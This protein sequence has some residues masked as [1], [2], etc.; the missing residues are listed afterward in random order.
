ML[1]CFRLYRLLEILECNEITCSDRER[2]WS[3]STPRTLI[4]F[5]SEL[6]MLLIIFTLVRLNSSAL[7]KLIN[8]GKFVWLLSKKIL[9]FKK[10]W[11]FRIHSFGIIGWLDPV[12]CKIDNCYEKQKFQLDFWPH[13]SLS[14]IEFFWWSRGGGMTWAISQKVLKFEIFRSRQMMKINLAWSRPSSGSILRPQWLS[15][16]SWKFPKPII[17]W[18]Q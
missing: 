12:N 9:L 18:W 5:S 1:I 16:I 14:L 6:G 2:S 7:S 10:S 4:D 13:S 3:K 11:K 17:I 15:W 8:S